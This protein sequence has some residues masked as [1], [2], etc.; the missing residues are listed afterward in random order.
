MRAIADEAGVSVMSL[1]NYAPSK[2]A[3]FAAV[4]QQSIE[5]VY[6]GYAESVDGLDSLA[7]ELDALIEQ[8]R[9]VLMDEPD[10]IMFVVRV[11]LEGRQPGLADLLLPVSSARDFL[12]QL[13]DR[14]VARGDIPACD[15]ERLILFV[16]TMFHGLTS[17]TA[18]DRA[19][20]DRAVDA[21]KWTVRRFIDGMPP[22]SKP[23]LQR[24]GRRACTS[25]RFR[26]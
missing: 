13:A 17:I 6:V 7:D 23:G 19:N 24:T 15:R 12:W 26:S 25:V 11:W 14:S 21:M 9:R 18:A 3:L 5:R 1:Y 20:L 16:A 8:S 4:W 10:H 2:A 22:G